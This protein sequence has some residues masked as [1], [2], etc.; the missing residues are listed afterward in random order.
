MDRLEELAKAAVEMA[1]YV[2]DV[3]PKVII[4]PLRSGWF[5]GNLVMEALRCNLGVKTYRYDPPVIPMELNYFGSYQKEKID[6]LCS[7]KSVPEFREFYKDFGKP[8]LIDCTSSGSSPASYITRN[9]EELTKLAKIGKK[10]YVNLLATNK[11]GQQE[12]YLNGLLENRSF[13]FR[14]TRVEGDSIMFDD[15]D[16]IMGLQCDFDPWGDMYDSKNFCK[17]YKK[18]LNRIKNCSTLQL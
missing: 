13:E 10:V 9:M 3:R 7:L 14:F 11:K 2:N 6:K 12:K 8:M 1:N 15:K 17:E 16:M 5:T 4:T 18:A